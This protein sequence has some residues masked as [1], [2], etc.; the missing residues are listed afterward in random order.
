ML[1]DNKSH[2]KVIDE[3]RGSLRAGTKMSVLTAWFSVFGYS[4]L[5]GELG[6]IDELRLL[7]ANA[8]ATDGLKLAGTL[9]ETGLKNQLNLQRISSE[10]ADQ[11][12]P[13]EAKPASPPKARKPSAGDTSCMPQSGQIDTDA[14]ESW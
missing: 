6:K 12:A 9:D 8:D 5:K 2:G 4:S 10:C 14:G 7:L 3:L 13:E 11:F 1:L